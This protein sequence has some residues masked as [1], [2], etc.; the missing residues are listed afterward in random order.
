MAIFSTL[1]SRRSGTIQTENTKQMITFRLYQ[2]WFALPILAVQKVIVLG[3]VYGD[4]QKKG[5]GLTAYE[6]QEIIVIDVAKFI[7]QDLPKSNLDP[8]DIDN[9]HASFF[10][11][12]LSF[13]VT[14]QQYL[15]IIDLPQS[16]PSS[17]GLPIDSQPVM[18]RVAQSAFKALPDAYLKQ[19]NIQCLSQKIIELTDCPPIFLFEPQSL[20]KIYNL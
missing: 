13:D 1:R 4:P 6:G 14:S 2:E 16:S 11:E 20:A 12:S 9:T 17:L 8:T 15:I 5:I 3:E 18:R 7:F 19:G 10:S